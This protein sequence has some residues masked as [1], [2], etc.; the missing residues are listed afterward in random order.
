MMGMRTVI[1]SDNDGSGSGDGDGSQSVVWKVG[2]AGA[3]HD[4]RSLFGPGN[5]APMSWNLESFTVLLLHT[6]KN[7]F[8]QSLRTWV[9]CNSSRVYKRQKIT[10]TLLIQEEKK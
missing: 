10:S 2:Q 4:S 7:K 5:H 8:D 3:W 6:G 1:D 9:A